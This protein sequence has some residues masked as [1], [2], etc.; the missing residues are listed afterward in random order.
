[1]AAWYNHLFWILLH[2]LWDGCKEIS[3]INSQGQ[4][5][6]EM[7]DNILWNGK[8]KNWKLQTEKPSRGKKIN[9]AQLQW[10][11]PIRGFR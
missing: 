3:I 4:R 2:F 9:S 11:A 5:A 8:L 1:M 7:D 6:K 10:G